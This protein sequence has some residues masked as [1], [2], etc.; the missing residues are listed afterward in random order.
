MAAVLEDYTSQDEIRAAVGS[1]DEELP[2]T[3]LDLPMYIQFLL[4]EL[5]GIGANLPADF[6]VV[7]A[8]AEESRT[9][10]QQNFYEAVRLF[11]PWAVAVFILPALPLI[12]QKSITDGKAAISRFAGEPWKQTQTD[13]KAMYERLRTALLAVYGVYLGSVS[14]TSARPYARV[15]SPATDPVTGE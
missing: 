13:V 2:D 14:S 7:V 4:A 5:R 9:T 8:I 15:S 1:T 11:C 12:A 6:A 3:V 10:A